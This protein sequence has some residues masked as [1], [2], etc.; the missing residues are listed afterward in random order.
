MKRLGSITLKKRSMRT[1]III[2]LIIGVA[3]GI[4]P[5]RDSLLARI[6]IAITGG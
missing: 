2:S 1:K 5:L 4:S 6:L 3:I